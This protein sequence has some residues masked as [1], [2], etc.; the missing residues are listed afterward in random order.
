MDKSYITQHEFFKTLD[1]N[2]LNLL[3]ENASEKAFL[4]G[5]C[6]FRQGEVANQFFLLKSGEVK[7][8]NEV[9]GRLVNQRI[10]QPGDV[11][12]WSWLVPPYVWS[13]TARAQS[14]TIVYE[15]DGIQLLVEC[16]NDPTTGYALFKRFAGM[17]GQRL[18]SIHDPGVGADRQMNLRD[19]ISSISAIEQDPVNR[20]RFLAV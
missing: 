19:M 4:G 18:A 15:F 17:M 3:T 1:D 8:G 11:I 5:D 14:E 20:K 10:L 7:I 16:E 12:G 2:V 6:L 9:D 13:T